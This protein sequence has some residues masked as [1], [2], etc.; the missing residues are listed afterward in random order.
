MSDLNVTARAAYAIRNFTALQFQ[1]REHTHRDWE[2]ARS[3]AVEALTALLRANPDTIGEQYCIT[4]RE[5][6]IAEHGADHW[7]DAWL[8]ANE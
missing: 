6:Y 5:R 8:G 2:D 3:Y 1:D 7:N 4:Y